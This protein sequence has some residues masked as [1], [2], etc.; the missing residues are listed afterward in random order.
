MKKTVIMLFI[1]MLSMASVFALNIEIPPS[2]DENAASFKIYLDE[3]GDRPY[4]V[5]ETTWYLEKK[6]YLIQQM[7]DG[8]WMLSDDD[9]CIVV[10]FGATDEDFE[11]LL[12]QLNSISKSLLLFIGID[13]DI[14]LETFKDFP[15][16]EIAV[17]SSTAEQNAYF[18][19]NG[20]KSTR[21]F[22]GSIITVNGDS[23]TYYGTEPISPTTPG[24]LV[25]C[26]H[27]GTPFY[28]M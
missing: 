14:S 25:Y 15:F 2:Y 18:N 22:P 19:R 9:N 6:G 24:R 4:I 5:D 27:C 21:I 16:K 11:F 1:C 13:S 17:T 8:I 23:V 26:P 10:A 28:V 7:D 3:K 20:K 12:F